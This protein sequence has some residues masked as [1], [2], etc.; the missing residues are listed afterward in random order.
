MGLPVGRA[1]ASACRRRLPWSLWWLPSSSGCTAR[2]WGSTEG[3]LGVL[4]VGRAFVQYA[5]PL[6]SRSRPSWSRPTRAISSQFWAGPA[7]NHDLRAPAQ[8][9]GRGRTCG[10][11]AGLCRKNPADSLPRCPVSTALT[12]TIQPSKHPAGIVGMMRFFFGVQRR[13]RADVSAVDTDTPSRTIPS[14]PPSLPGP[15]ACPRVPV[16]ASVSEVMTLTCLRSEETTQHPRAQNVPADGRRKD[17]VDSA[18]R[19]PHNGGEPAG[20]YRLTP[21]AR[22]RPSR[23]TY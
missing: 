15:A 7:S 23:S 22:E 16:R 5:Q 14:A 13:C 21:L 20:C 10:G 2:G 18:D 17:D 19:R 9:A 11:G 8:A 4:E 6:A 1:A 12:S 3:G